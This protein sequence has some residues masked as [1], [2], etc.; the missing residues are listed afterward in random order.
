MPRIL[1][2]DDELIYHKMV[3]SALE[4]EKYQLD[5]ALTG[6]EGLQKAKTT[7]PD[8]IITDVVMPDMSG[9]EVAKLLRRD[10]QF[11]NLPILVLSAQ[12]ALQN[13][14]SSFEAG[15][16]DYLSKPFA[17]EELVVRLA[18]LLRRSELSQ[19]PVS[20]AQVHAESRLIAVHSLKGGTGCSSLAINLGVSL[21]SLWKHSTILL[22]LNMVAG[23]VALML[24]A[25]LR[26][27]WADIAQINSGE[28]EWDVLESIIAKHES[29]VAFIAAPTFPGEAEMIHADILDACLHLLKQRYDYMLADLPHDFGDIVVHTLDMADLILVMAAP[30]VASLRATAA[31]LDTYTKLNYPSEKIRLILN[32]TFPK[33]GLQKDKIEAALGIP[34]ML[35]IPYA[36]DLFVQ[37][38]NY[39]QPIVST[40]PEEPVAA[41]LENLAFSLS[42]DAHKKSRPDNPSEAWKR[43]YERYSKRKK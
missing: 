30:D 31:A 24:N 4:K 28:F 33:Y 26:R 13:K 3:A 7:H 14:L 43:V 41:L 8:L 32:A 6:S 16:D 9:Y 23:Q 11:A 25:T 20:T 22:D 39:G 27:T 19:V 17:P 35:V 10:P 29:G 36:S 1:V 38:I 37:A 34:V 18:A 40:K 5:F 15:A 21:A 12:A 2:I 42:M